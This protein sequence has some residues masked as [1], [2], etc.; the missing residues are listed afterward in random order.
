MSAGDLVSWIAERRAV[1]AGD[2]VGMAT[3]SAAAD[4]VRELPTQ[5]SEVL[6]AGGPRPGRPPRGRR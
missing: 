2:V 5:R 4:T 1:A 3:P 6:V